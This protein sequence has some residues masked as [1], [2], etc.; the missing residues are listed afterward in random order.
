[1]V[2]DSIECPHCSISNLVG[3]PPDSTYVKAHS[4]YQFGERSKIQ[5]CNN[6]GD[7]NTFY[8]LR[9]NLFLSIILNES[10]SE[11]FCKYSCA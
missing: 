2:L 6:S 7:E 5:I 8:C 4:E 10:W 1:M 9:H 3:S 11:Y